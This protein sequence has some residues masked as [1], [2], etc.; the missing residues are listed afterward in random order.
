MKILRWGLIISV[1][2]SLGLFLKATDF[3]EVF[4][5]L[6]KIGAKA[7]IILLSTCAAYLLGTWG[8]K[9]CLGENANT[10]SFGRLFVLRHVGETLA[11]FNPTSILAGDWLK[12]HGLQKAGINPE[13]A[14]NSVILSRILMILTQMFLLICALSWMYLGGNLEEKWRLG[15]GILLGILL[16]TLTVL[17]ILLF[18]DV[19]ESSS[20]KWWTTLKSYKNALRNYV[21]QYP[22]YSILAALFLMLHWIAGSLEMYFILS[23]LGYDLSV[24]HG[25]LMDMGVILIKSIG[26]FIPGQLGLEEIANKTVILLIGISSASLWVSVSILKRS[27]QMFW[28]AI[29]GIL[30]LLYRKEI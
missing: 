19:D 22:K 1:I 2:I 17:L 27:R 15:V 29:G 16:I 14:N 30:Y 26:A 13:V 25:L 4:E 3:Q 12:S 18:K 23:Y 24:F 7:F 9:Y 6:K 11:L 5:I 21:L 28:S 8:W 20:Y 10:L